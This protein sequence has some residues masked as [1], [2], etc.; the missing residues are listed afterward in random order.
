M[1]ESEVTEEELLGYLSKIDPRARLLFDRDARGRASG[2]V[3]MDKYQEVPDVLRQQR[4]REELTENA[5][6]RVSKIGALIV[7]SHAE[8]KRRSVQKA[9]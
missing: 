4:L 7:F 6:L 8:W 9:S 3:I 2:I 5:P 1:S